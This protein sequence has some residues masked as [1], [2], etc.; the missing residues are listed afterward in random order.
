MNELWIVAAA[1]VGLAI[2][3]RMRSRRNTLPTR[4]LQPSA[5]PRIHGSRVVAYVHPRM[6]T[7]CL[8]DN[9]L[10]FGKGFRRKE[11]PQLPHSPACR[12]EV[13]SFAFTASEVFNGA[14]RN[15]GAV[16]SSLPGLQPADG[17]RLIDR[18]KIVEAQP[19]PADADAYVAAVAVDTFPPELQ[20]A[21]RDFAAERHAFLR[22]AAAEA[23]GRAEP[24]TPDQIEPSE[25]T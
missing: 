18:L 2:F 3:A 5:G 1:I 24:I 17:L 15:V 6:S 4:R 9:G 23:A 22:S 16:K 8:F 13:V 19:L 20:P 11:G 21:L 10:Q 25:T 14:L 12:C 7:A